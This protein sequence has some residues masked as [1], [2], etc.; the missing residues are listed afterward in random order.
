MRVVEIAPPLVESD[1]HRT[2][3]DPNAYTKE[4]TGGMALTMDEFIEQIEQGMDQ[5]L[6]ECG[7]GFSKT[8]IKKAHDA[9]GEWF[10][11]VNKR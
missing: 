11:K 1:L 7:A 5:G 4:K 10:E 3:A 2:H 8:F 6:D 9:Y